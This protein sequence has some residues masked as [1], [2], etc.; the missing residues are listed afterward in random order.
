MQVQSLPAELL[1]DPFGEPVETEADPGGP[2]VLDQRPPAALELL[3]SREIVT[4]DPSRD[5]RHQL[6]RLVERVLLEARQACAGG[7]L[8]V[9][10]EEHTSELQ[11]RF[12]LVCR[13]LLEKKKHKN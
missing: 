7:V 5:P 4:D 6:R 10:S 2:R 12:D 13:L 1:H 8:G 11:S 3:C 9:R